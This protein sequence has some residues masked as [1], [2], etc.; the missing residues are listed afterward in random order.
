MQ[1]PW[2]L[3]PYWYSCE[4]YS[5]KQNGSQIRCMIHL[6]VCRS[7][8]KGLVIILPSLRRMFKKENNCTL[9]DRINGCICAEDVVGVE[10]GY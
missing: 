7:D 5:C 8:R 1:E 3:R 9:I 2:Q 10:S 4:E 6:S